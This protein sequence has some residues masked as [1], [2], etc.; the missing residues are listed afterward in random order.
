MEDGSH[1]HCL[2]VA[3]LH[4]NTIIADIPDKCFH[5]QG[6]TFPASVADILHGKELFLAALHNPT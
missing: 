3:K 6:S 1:C 2:P 4:G 5:G